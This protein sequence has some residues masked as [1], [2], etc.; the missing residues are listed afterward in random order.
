[1]CLHLIALSVF[2][3]ILCPDIRFLLSSVLGE[4]QEILA[5]IVLAH[6]LSDVLKLLA[7][8]PSLLEGYLLK[9][10]HLQ[11]LSLLNHLDKGACRFT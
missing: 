9:A 4:L 3:F 1:M 6:G 8:Y 11:S 10:S 7:V 2:Y 5:I